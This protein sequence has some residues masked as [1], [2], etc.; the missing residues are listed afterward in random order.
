[1]EEFLH[2]K[3]VIGMILGLGLTNL[4]KESVKFVNHPER[5]KPYWVH[6]LWVFYLFLMLIHFW[7]WEISLRTITKWYFIDYFFLICYVLLYYV[8][9]T[10]LYP[11]DLRGYSSFK[12]YFYSRKPWF[13]GILGITFLADV[14][15][16]YIKGPD[17]LM[18]ANHEYYIHIA[19]NFTLCIIAIFT[20]NRLFHKLLVLA[21]LAYEIL[22]IARFYN[23]EV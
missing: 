11:E 14:V 17:Y 9:S 15:D 2:I 3:T 7:W 10:L 18:V 12:D 20:K 23:I 21:F 19:L 22:F 1:M 4:I 13:F 8:L 5:N 16:T 6:L